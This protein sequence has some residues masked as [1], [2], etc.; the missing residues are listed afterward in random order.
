MYYFSNSYTQ[1]NEFDLVFS[2]WI[3]VLEQHFNM[4]T[5]TYSLSYSST[6]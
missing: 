1:I 2:A 5:A 3:V 4:F 6:F